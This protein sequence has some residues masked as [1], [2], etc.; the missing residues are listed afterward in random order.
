MQSLRHKLAQTF[1]N[2]SDCEKKVF[3]QYDDLET[4]AVLTLKD[5]RTDVFKIRSQLQKINQPCLIGLCFNENSAE[6][7]KLVP[8]ILVSHPSFCLL[9]PLY[10]VP[11]YK[12]K[13]PLQRQQ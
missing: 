4:K 3:I 11:C 9:P 6:I 1:Q 12:A 2:I 5:F 8:S 10:A 13:K 7:I